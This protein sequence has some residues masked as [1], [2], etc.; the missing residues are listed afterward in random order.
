MTESDMSKHLIIKRIGTNLRDEFRD[1]VDAPMP[2][3]MRELLDRIAHLERS[4]APE[5]C[6]RR[7]CRG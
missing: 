5:R 4:A 3:G 6:D 7:R 1:V 2:E